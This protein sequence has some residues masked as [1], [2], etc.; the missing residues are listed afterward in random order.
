[1]P[2]VSVVI[3]AYNASK[4]INETILSVCNQSL[5]DLE[6][7]VVD[8]GSTDN[9][10]E[11]I[12]NIAIKENRIKYLFQKNSGV[13]SARNFGFKNSS[14]K[15]IAFL[16]ADDL[17][18]TNNLTKKVEALN[19]A[20]EHYGLVHSDV[21]IIDSKGVVTARCLCG[22]K[23]KVLDDLLLWNGTVIPAPSSILLKRE[24]LDKIGLFDVELSTA[25]D[26]EFF[27]RIAS[28]YHIERLP[29]KLVQYRV[30]DSNMHSNIALMESD[31]LLAYKKAKTNKLFKSKIFELHCFSNLY[32]ILAGSWWKNGKNKSR[33]AYFLAKALLVYPPS[34]FKL[35]RKLM[36]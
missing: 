9:T 7:I 1:M 31:H 4:F 16:D 12:Q 20:E 35:F 2:L 30:H 13:S 15:F 5:V 34:F 24:V 27:F 23:G 11:I 22:K 29:E 17:W 28:Q 36:A 32:I 6:I 3:P 18:L 10:A 21:Q 19:T 25:A 33:G 8:D 26:Q 14:G